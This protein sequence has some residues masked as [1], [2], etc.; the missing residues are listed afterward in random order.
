[1]TS[2]V[3]AQQSQLTQLITEPDCAR[4]DGCEMRPPTIGIILKNGGRPI[5]AGTY[6]AAYTES[7]RIIFG[8][9]TYIIGSG[10][11]LATNNDEWRLSLE[12]LPVPLSPGEFEL[13]VEAIGY[14]GTILRAR[15]IIVLSESDIEQGGGALP[16][17]DTVDVPKPNGVNDGAADNS[18]V[19][20]AIVQ[21]AAIGALILFVMLRRKRP[22]NESKNVV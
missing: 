21:A 17:D 20:L 22:K 1:M 18:L 19:S 16:P 4:P 8:G 6:D 9:T 3:S 2:P 13:T 10:G 12:G 5:I 14:N 11:F 7:L 15:V